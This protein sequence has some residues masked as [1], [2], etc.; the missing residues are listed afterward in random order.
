MKVFLSY[1][2][3]DHAALVDAVFD[4]LNHPPKSEVLMIGDS[5]HDL[6]VAN[7]MGVECVLVARGHQDRETLV[8]NHD[9]VVDDIREVQL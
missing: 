6:E 8:R 9:R 1:G 2:H 4:A 5:L 3:N 7:A